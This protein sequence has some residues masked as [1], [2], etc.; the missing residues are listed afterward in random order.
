MRLQT[1]RCFDDVHDGIEPAAD[2]AAHWSNLIGRMPSAHDGGSVQKIGRL[3]ASF[4]STPADDGNGLGHED[5]EEQRR[6]AISLQR[7]D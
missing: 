2:V 6:V 3:R 5:V 7:F 1:G 4:L